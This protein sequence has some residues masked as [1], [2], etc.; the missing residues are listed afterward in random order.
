V[1]RSRTTHLLAVEN[2]TARHQGARLSSAQVQRLTPEAIDQMGLPAEVALAMQANLAVIQTL[3]EQIGLLEKRLAEKL[4]PRAEY[5]LL[6]TVPGIGP[7]LASIILLEVGSIERFASAGNFASYARCVDHQRTRILVSS[8]DAGANPCPEGI[9]D[10]FR[11][12]EKPATG[13]KSIAITCSMG[14]AGAKPHRPSHGQ[15]SRQ[16][17]S[18]HERSRAF[19]FKGG[20]PVLSRS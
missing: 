9:S 3:S 15:G 11:D 6:K 20:A 19:P 16:R 2:I 4:G 8:G 13:C 7:I 18:A 10:K 14:K 1:V 17:R 12:L 5:V